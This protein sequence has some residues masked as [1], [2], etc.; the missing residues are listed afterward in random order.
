MHPRPSWFT[1][2]SLLVLLTA[3]SMCS[4]PPSVIPHSY[5]AQLIKDIARGTEGSAPTELTIVDDILF[6]QAN[7]G[8]NGRELWKSDGTAASTVLV[9]DINPMPTTTFAQAPTGSDPVGWSSASYLTPLNRTLFFNADDGVHG[10][11]LWKSDGTTAGTTMVL[12][13]ATGGAS[14]EPILG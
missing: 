5:T 12:D 3:L 7:D 1:V 13:I 11:E 6:F 4:A 8:L 9:K 10:R 14:A 2:C